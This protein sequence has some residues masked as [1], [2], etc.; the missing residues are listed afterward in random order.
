MLLML[1]NW[2]QYW[3]NHKPREHSVPWGTYY[4]ADK[5]A[6]LALMS[7]Q[8]LSLSTVEVMWLE[9]SW[10]VYSGVSM[11]TTLTGESLAPFI[12]VASRAT[13]GI[14]DLSVGNNPT[15]SLKVWWS[16]PICVSTSFM[17]KP[18]SEGPDGLWSP[19]DIVT[20]EFRSTTAISV[21]II[22]DVGLILLDIDFC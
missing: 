15:W 8:I 1:V 9:Q 5:G 16:L 14:T 10:R 4:I 2:G 19:Q 18:D 20:A 21:T 12:R 22:G 13:M 7:V 6:E 3:Y 17:G 11:R